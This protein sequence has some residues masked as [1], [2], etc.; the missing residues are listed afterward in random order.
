M[1]TNDSTIVGT[2]GGTFLSIVPNIHSED[3][4]RTAI[5]ATVGALVSFMISLLLKSLQKKLKK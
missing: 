4:A 2:I 1:T 5:L 3:I